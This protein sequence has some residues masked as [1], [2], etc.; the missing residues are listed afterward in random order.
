ML[1]ASSTYVCIVGN[2]KTTGELPTQREGRSTRLSVQGKVQC[3]III[4]LFSLRCLRRNIT[5]IF[6]RAITY[7]TH[8]EE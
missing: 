5:N 6:I 2:F 3:I 1:A 4:H 7:K 8:G